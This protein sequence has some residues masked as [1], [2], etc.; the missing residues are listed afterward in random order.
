M[1]ERIV[2]SAAKTATPV[3][4]PDCSLCVRSFG[5]LLLRGERLPRLHPLVHRVR[6]RSPGLGEPEDADVGE[7]LVPVD[8]LVGDLGGRIGPLLELLDD[9][10]ELPD[11]RVS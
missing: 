1:S 3:G 9:P 11:R 6:G 10:G 4:G 2:E 8:G 5:R 7:Q